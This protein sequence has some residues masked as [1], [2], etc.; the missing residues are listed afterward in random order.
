MYDSTFRFTIVFYEIVM[1]VFLGVPTVFYGITSVLLCNR[2][3]R[4]VEQIPLNIFVITI[5]FAA[6]RFTPD[7]PDNRVVNLEHLKIYD[8]TGQSYKTLPTVVVTPVS[9]T[10]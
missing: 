8:P 1:I 2:I 10:D 5:Y 4:T 6:Y 3:L 7:S 9:Y